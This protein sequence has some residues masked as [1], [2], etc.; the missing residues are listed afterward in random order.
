MG[1]DVHEEVIRLQK[2]RRP[3]GTDRLHRSGRRRD[4]ED[5]GT[6]GEHAGREV[7]GRS[8]LHARGLTLALGAVRSTVLLEEHGGAPH[9]H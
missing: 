4:S 1:C 5:R 2:L 3:R 6:G 8:H 7:W 9:P